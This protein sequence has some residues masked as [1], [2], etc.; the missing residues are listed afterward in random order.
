MFIINNT[1]WHL[2]LNHFPVIGM[3]L[4]LVLWGMALSLDIPQL[5]QTT[6]VWIMAMGA[7]TILV[8]LTGTNSHELIH[9][10]PGVRH[11]FIDTHQQ[12]GTYSLSA[13]LLASLTALV[14]LIMMQRAGGSLS[15]FWKQCIFLTVLVSVGLTFY[16]AHLGGLI[17]HTEI[18]PGFTPA[19]EENIESSIETQGPDNQTQEAHSHEHSHHH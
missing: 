3:I 7:I 9:G 1:H 4:G 11:E 10:L 14:S 5:Y 18:R 8:Y 15:R 19:Q 2:M 6:L 16:T 17:R 13:L 12:W